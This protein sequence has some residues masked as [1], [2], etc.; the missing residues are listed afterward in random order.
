ATP[1]PKDE[2]VS[3]PPTDGTTIEQ[4]DSAT[5]QTPGNPQPKGTDPNTVNDAP[6]G[7]TPAAAQPKPPDH[8]ET[9][10]PTPADGGGGNGIAKSLIGFVGGGGA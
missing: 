7:Q 1:A 3:P 9:P 6:T 8:V 5:N 10:A 4:G 2:A